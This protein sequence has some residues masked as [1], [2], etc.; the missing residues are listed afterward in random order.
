MQVVIPEPKT[1]DALTN[2]IEKAL[3]EAWS[4]DMAQ[5]NPVANY[6]SECVDD[7]SLKAPKRQNTLEALTEDQLYFRGKAQQLKDAVKN[8]PRRF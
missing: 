5:F 6:I 4:H 2:A 1:L 7:G 3:I 8:Q